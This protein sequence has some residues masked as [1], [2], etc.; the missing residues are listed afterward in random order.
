M[1]AHPD[2]RKKKQ[3]N[4]SLSDVYPKSQANRKYQAHYLYPIKALLK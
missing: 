4:L 2:F 3:Q 1:L